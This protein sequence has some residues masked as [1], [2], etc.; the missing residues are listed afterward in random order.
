M[1]RISI[2]GF[3][4]SRFCPITPETSI[5]QKRLIMQNEPN[6]QNTQ[7]ERKFLHHNNYEPRT[8]NNEQFKT[9]PKRTQSNPI[10]EK[11]SAED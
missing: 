7:N 10:Y 5:N 9:N 11:P 8:M 4:I 1:F 6:F 2:L 3:R